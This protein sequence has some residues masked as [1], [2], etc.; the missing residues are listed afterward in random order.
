MR[1]K[2]VRLLLET[3]E[4]RLNPSGNLIVNGDFSQG[5][6]GFQSLYT[7]VDGNIG[8]AQTYDVATGWSVLTYGDH[9]TGSGRMLG[10]NGSNVANIA[11]WSQ[12][13]SVTPNTDYTYSF[14]V[15]SWYPGPTPLAVKVDD[16]T[17]A[18][19]QAPA[20]TGQWQKVSVAWNSGAKTS[21]TFSM[22]A[23]QGFDIGGDFAIDDISLV[24]TNRPPTFSSLNNQNSFLGSKISLG[25]A[26]AFSDPDSD[27]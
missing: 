5:N 14:W 16:I 24:G 7:R 18:T 23:T 8:G 6:T 2:H 20:Q 17:I 11:F 19:A 27:P 21:A 13:V 15:S 9:T 10:V 22:L 3:L 12:S 25:V 4:S 1:R 26:Q